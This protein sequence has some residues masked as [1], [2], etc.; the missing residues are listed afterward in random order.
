[1]S[2]SNPVHLWRFGRTRTL[3]F[4]QKWLNRAKIGVL[5]GTPKNF[6]R[7]NKS[8]SRVF[9]T[10]LSKI[11]WKIK[12]ISSGLVTRRLYFLKKYD[13]K[14]PKFPPC[15]NWPI[16]GSLYQCVLFLYILVLVL[17]I[18]EVPIPNSVVPNFSR[19]Y[20]WCFLLLR[21][22]LCVFLSL[23]YPVNGVAPSPPSSP[24]SSSSSTSSFHS[25][26]AWADHLRCQNPSSQAGLLWI[27]RALEELQH[28]L[29]AA[30]FPSLAR[31][32]G[33]DDIYNHFTKYLQ[34][35]T[36]CEPYSLNV[37]KSGKQERRRW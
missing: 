17:P 1:M 15:R 13:T 23:C 7:P 27:D 10:Q 14:W 12:S 37:H 21:S 30:N 36:I 24:F 34:L 28:D 18:F 5:H 32:R 3:I 16:C 8:V 26:S 2:K 11:N 25:P 22:Y 29:R 33:G 31:K 19:S 6:L 4:T 9:K 35:F 20:V